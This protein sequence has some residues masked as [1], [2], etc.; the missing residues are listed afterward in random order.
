MRISTKVSLSLALLGLAVFGGLG[1]LQLVVEKRDLEQALVREASTLCRATAESLRQDLLEREP[2]DSASLLEGL[3]R[4]ENDLDVTVWQPDAPLDPAAT[5]AGPPQ[6]LVDAVGREASTTGELVIAITEQ[7]DDRRVVVVASP[8]DPARA[9][10]AVVLVRPLDS[11]D[12]DLRREAEVT[13]SSV[14]VFSVLGG[15]LGFVLGEIYIRRPLERLDRAMAGVAGGDLDAPLSPGRPDEVG[16]VLERFDQMRQ[17]LQ[18]ARMRLEAEQ[19][20]HRT[21]LERLAD[22]DRLA[23]IG[24]L[25]AGLAHEIGSPLQ[26][27]NGRAQKLA[28]RVGHDQYLAGGMEIIVA[29]TERITRIVRQLLEFA[30]PR[31]R[32][33]RPADPV[34]SIR[35]VVDLL[36]LETRRRN[37]SVRLDAEGVGEMVEIDGDALQQIVFNLVRNSLAALDPGG[38]IEIGLA[39]EPATGEAPRVLVL[40][41]ADNGRGIPDDVRARI[42]EPFFTTRAHDG[43]VGLGLAVVRALVDAMRGSVVATARAEGGT[44]LVVRVPC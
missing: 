30:R 2:L 5:E 21:T 4:F 20:A 13:A 24:H 19:D 31:A 29:Q 3:E 33:R 36:E 28:K 26:I 22:A 40:R 38:W 37:V 32:E 14:L 23:T 12:A 11:I 39:V 25:A 1:A 27:L 44:E 15:L 16:R 9:A 35:A 6:A 8:I 43:G 18:R 34:A 7:G 10:G 42:F 17:E 41:V